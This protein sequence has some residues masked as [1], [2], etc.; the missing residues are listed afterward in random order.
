MR[1]PTLLHPYHALSILKKIHV[2]LSV[3]KIKAGILNTLAYHTAGSYAIVRVK[4]LQSFV[5]WLEVKTEIAIQLQLKSIPHFT[6]L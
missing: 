3:P 4:K 1:T 2:L 5:Q 6:T